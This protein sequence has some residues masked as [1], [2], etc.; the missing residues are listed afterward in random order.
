MVQYFAVLLILCISGGSLKTTS[1][2]QQQNTEKVKDLCEVRN[3]WRSQTLY[4]TTFIIAIA[5]CIPIYWKSFF[6]MIWQLLITVFPRPI[7]QLIGVLVFNVQFSVS[8]FHVFFVSTLNY[9]S[10]L[11]S[12]IS[13]VF[14]RH[15]RIQWHAG[16]ARRSRSSRTPGKGRY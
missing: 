12:T 3:A 1:S 2:P 13:S 15:P 8:N 5:L 9:K 7:I 14:P 11:L 6:S 16:N 4:F 10:C